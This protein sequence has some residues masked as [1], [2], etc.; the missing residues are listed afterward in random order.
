[1]L[2]SDT[3]EGSYDTINPC[4]G[5]EKL[6]GVMNMANNLTISDTTKGLKMT[7]IVTNN[8]MSVMGANNGTSMKFDSGPFSV[9]FETF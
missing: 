7:F 2:V 6:L 1:M 3:E 8:G 5:H 4:T 9:T